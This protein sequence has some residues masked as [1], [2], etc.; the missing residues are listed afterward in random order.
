MSY[1]S[2]LPYIACL[3]MVALKQVNSYSF[4]RFNNDNRSV[5]SSCKIRYE[6]GRLTTFSSPS[7]KTSVTSLGMSNANPANFGEITA[8][9]ALLDS[10]WQQ[11]KQNSPSNKDKTP[12][13]K[14]AIPKDIPDSSTSSESSNSNP[15]NS[16][17]FIYYLPPLSSE[18]SKPSKPTSVIL[19]LGGAGLG[20]YPHIT[21]DNLLTRL[22]RKSNSAILAAP[23]SVNLDHFELAKKSGDLLRRAVIMLED[24][25]LDP[26]CTMSEET[27]KYA[28]CHSL[29]AKLQFIFMAATSYH[30]DLKGVGMMAYNNFGLA[31]SIQMTQSYLSD[32]Q[33]DASSTSQNPMWDNIFQFAEQAIST[34]GIDFTPS[35]AQMDQLLSLKFNQDMRERTRLFV[36]QQDDLDSSPSF[37]NATE[38]KNNEDNVEIS[39]LEGTHLTPV[40]LQFKISDLEIEE[41]VKSVMGQFTNDIQQISWGDE[42]HL[43]SLVEEVSNWMKGKPPSES[44]G[45][46]EYQPRLSGII[47]AEIE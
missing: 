42:V 38:S 9:L 2:W 19:F 24:G 43:D 1:L 13:Q 25:T 23:Y 8:T 44:A 21:Y 4:S 15:Q 28:L 22:S 40:Y 36:F 27:P 47:D 10:Q 16:Q 12:W 17:E 5:F 11:Q 29:G 20:Q 35:P 3:C 39:N 41:E 31:A 26:N 34:V 37:L 14:I 7:S 18:P 6:Q 46:Y 32:A 30:L 45:K 33:N